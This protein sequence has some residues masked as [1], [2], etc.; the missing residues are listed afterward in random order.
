[1]FVTLMCLSI[2]CCGLAMA[3]AI[4]N[5]DWLVIDMFAFTYLAT[6]MRLEDVEIQNRAKEKAHAQVRL[7]GLALVHKALASARAAKTATTPVQADPGQGD[8]NSATVQDA[9][10]PIKDFSDQED[11][12]PAPVKDA[13][14]LVKDCS[15][16]EDVTFL[17]LQDAASAAAGGGGEP[18][19]VPAAAGGGGEP[20]PVPAAGGGSE[21]P[22][23]PRL[24]H[25]CRKPGRNGEPV[26]L[27]IKCR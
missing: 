7:D 27:C 9:A 1:M 25:Y 5:A 20:P 22:P 17:P 6:M 15:D 4:R 21:P 14:A 13:A 10:A 2:V 23:A 11:A 26:R 12:S 16:Q 19:T 24:C 18:P 8:A 3:M